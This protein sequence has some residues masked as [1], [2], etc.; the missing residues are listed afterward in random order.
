MS[1]KK[2]TGFLGINLKIAEVIKT[3]A[4]K[5]AMDNVVEKMASE[6]VSKRVEILDKAIVKYNDTKKELLNCKPDA[7]TLSIVKNES[8]DDQG[9]PISN[10][11]W[12]PKQYEKK[13]KLSKLI[14]DLDAAFMHAF[15]ENKPDWD[16]LKKLTAGGGN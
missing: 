3:T 16:K 12:T 4:N 5:R 11:Q 8:G 13:L 15:D 6:E 7:T 9:G 10:E 1:E 14:A 2:V